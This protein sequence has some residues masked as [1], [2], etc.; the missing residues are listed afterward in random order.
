[1]PAKEIKFGEQ[2][3]AGF[4]QG[5]DVLARAVKITMG[6][7]GRYVFLDRHYG[8]RLTRDGVGV[9]RM[10]D[11]SDRFA[12][13]GAQLMRE[14]AV[15]TSDDTGDGATTATVLAHAIV[16]EGAKAVAAGMNPMDLRRGIDVAVSLVV[17]EIRKRSRK[18]STVD[19]IVK[20]ATVT[21]NDD[22][23][24][25]RMVAEAMDKAG[26]EGVITVE[27]GNTL[28]SELTVVEGLQFDRGYVS[29]HLVNDAATMTC[30]LEDPYILVY[31]RKVSSFEPLVSL[32]ESV[33][34]SD[35]PFLVIAEG[36]EG[37][38]LSALVV[39]KLRGGLE[40]AAVEGPSFG[41]QR[42][43]LLDDIAVLTGARIMS[44]ELGLKLEDATL[45]MLGTAKR[46][47]ITGTTTTLV[48]GGGEKKEIRERCDQIRAQIR[49][50]PSEYDREKLQERLAKLAGGVAVIRVGGASELEVKER[51]DR[52]DAALRASRAALEE[53]ILP[54]GGVALLH[55]ARSL[56]KASG[57]NADQKAGI[58]I[59]RRALREPVRQIVENAGHQASIVVGKLWERGD[60]NLGF[61]VRNG[62]YADMVARGIID[63][64]KVIRTALQNAASVAA[65]LVTTEAMVALIPEPEE[66]AK[67]A[68][69]MGDLA[70]LDGLDDDM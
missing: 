3:R 31:D 41:E 21:S 32:L 48:E 1:M 57:E 46:A 10:I 38:A 39:N 67:P 9:A 35:R 45:E 23:D 58:D 24:I 62:A 19:E 43:V 17:D 40:T 15:K 29:P 7:K 2:A 52:F 69:P 49:E 56:D 4:L 61:D 68:D 28:D 65:L 34:Q 60:G 13:M 11:L 27:E 22:P 6:P 14:V 51:R 12:D 59:V 70:D 25:G 47:I 37:E 26:R 50:N 64:T 44:E 33:L 54:G 5:V 18:V 66:P 55:A 53:G 8:T 16:L 20:V 63:S 30:E 42:K 36:I